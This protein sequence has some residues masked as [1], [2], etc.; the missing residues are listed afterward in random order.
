MDNRLDHQYHGYLYELEDDGGN[1]HPGDG[2]WK[3]QDSDPEEGTPI[4]TIL[5]DT[6]MLPAYDVPQPDEF[7][8]LSMP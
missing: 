1:G 3:P 7:S 5:E 2:R 6:N 4:W 8:V